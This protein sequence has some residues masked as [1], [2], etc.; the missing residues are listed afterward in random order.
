ML[1]K[2]NETLKEFERICRE[3]DA[4][5]HEI[6]CSVNLSDS[7][8]C[9]LRTF[10]VLGDELTQTEIYRFTCLN[11]QTVN[12]SIKK[13][14]EDG[15]IY[16]HKRKGKEIKISLTEKG[17]EVINSKILPIEL[18]E[19]EIFDEMPM[20][21]KEALIRINRYYLSSFRKKLEEL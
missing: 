21:D 1:Y 12:S 16:L 14:K 6:A 19:S 7:A 17:K 5:Y 4:L 2:Q 13:L 10:L 11:K 18:K 9:I 8:Y 3:I 20:E 15:M